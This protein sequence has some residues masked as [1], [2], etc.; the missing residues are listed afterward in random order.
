MT[1]PPW[2]GGGW[3]ICVNL[4]QVLCEKTPRVLIAQPRRGIKCHGYGAAIP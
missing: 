1:S 2:E 3:G 4:R